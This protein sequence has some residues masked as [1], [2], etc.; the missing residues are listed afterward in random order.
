MI[1]KQY[2]EVVSYLAPNW[3]IF[4]QAVASYLGR[5][6][7]MEIDL[8]QGK[9]DSLVDPLLLKD[10][11][12]LAFICGLP[13][14][15][16]CQTAPYQLQ[17]LVAPVMAAP[18]YQQRPIYFADVIV[19]SASQIHQFSDLQ[20]KLFCYNDLGSNSGYNLLRY[21]L[22]Q[23][24][25]S[26]PFFSKEMQ[27]GSH[28]TS[29]RW[30]A[31]GIADCAA[32]DSIVLEQELHDFPELAQHVRVVEVLRNSP[33]PPLVAA[34][35]LGSSLITQIC[36]CLLC[37]DEELQTAMRKVGISYFVPVKLEDYRVL[38]QMYEARYSP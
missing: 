29:I 37:P 5:V 26:Q 2:L 10:R 23:D 30:V 38:L 14:I 3:F 22:I 25:Y 35:H 17:T 6:L 9:V 11:L 8:S 32:I 13:L 19:N 1:Q 24:K 12:D 16:Y 15:R 31:K 27:S 7:G 4:Y 20:E 33:I 21:K 36:T 18:R 34:T 28:Q